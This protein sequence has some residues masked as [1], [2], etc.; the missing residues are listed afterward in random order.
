MQPLKEVISRFKIP[1]KTARKLFHTFIG[2]IALYT[3]ECWT[4]LNEKH[5]LNFNDDTLIGDKDIFK[6]DNL[7]RQFLK[8][9][10]GTS[11][12][13]PNLAVYGELGEIPISLK[14]YRLM[15]NYWY[16]TNSLPTSSFVKLALLE[17][18][19]LR[20]DW[21]KF[22]EHILRFFNLTEIPNSMSK[23]KTKGDI[24]IQNKYINNWSTKLRENS[25]SRLL[26]Y[27]KI[28]RNF[29]FETCLEF[30]NY[31]QRKVISKF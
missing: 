29:L 25:S 12:S 8:Y 27:G 11:K 28:K 22:V 31:H 14:A 23:F 5:I 20:S 17:N 6:V 2:P 9:I 7:H 26:F 4:V 30:T 24:N 10:L 19:D 13:C 16:R 18:I 3:S 21:I 1:V 15:V